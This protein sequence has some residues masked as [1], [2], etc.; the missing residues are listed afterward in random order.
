M[1]LLHTAAA[2]GHFRQPF[3]LRGLRDTDPD[4]APLRERE[5][6]RKLIRQ[7]EAE[8]SSPAG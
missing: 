7:L 5:D 6:F 1:E 8:M 2:T 4:I 3:Q